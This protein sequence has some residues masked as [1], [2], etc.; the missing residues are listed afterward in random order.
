[1]RRRNKLLPRYT[2]NGWT[3]EKRPNTFAEQYA[4]EATA[5]DA[6]GYCTATHGFQSLTAA[7]AF[8]EAH[9]APAT[10]HH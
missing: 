10:R 2:A 8:C 3:I 1:M 5:V 9:T 6:E 4:W 7:R